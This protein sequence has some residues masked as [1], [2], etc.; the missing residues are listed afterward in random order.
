[1]A[2]KKADMLKALAHPIRIMIFEELANGEK[3]VGELVEIM[4]T[5][6]ANTSRHLAVMRKAGLLSSRKEGLNVFYSIKI[7]CFLSMLSCIDEGVCSIAEDQG[8]AAFLIKSKS[9]L[10]IVSDFL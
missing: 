2:E 3:Q 4:G 10:S 7:Q 8:Q 5:K 6:E 9:N 1:M